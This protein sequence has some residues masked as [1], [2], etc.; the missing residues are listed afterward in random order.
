MRPLFTVHAGEYLVATEIEASFRNLRVW[1]PSKDTGVDLLVTDSR[2]NKVAALQVKFSKDYLA[3]QSGSIVTP[4][5]TSGGWWTLKRDKIEESPADLWVLV[6]YQFHSRQFDFVVIPP[7]D[8]LE[9][10]D[11][12][13]PKADPIQS[14]IWVTRQRRC[15]ETR[16]LEK[17]A[18]RDVR[19]GTYVNASR[20]L[21]KYLNDWAS[22]KSADASA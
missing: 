6:L 10:Y 11:S 3:T 9:R 4:E 18:I 12:I 20:D 2:H 15:W 14:Y 8:L 22:L 1:V 16:G 19:D 21:T 7:R 17:S 5:I 13:A